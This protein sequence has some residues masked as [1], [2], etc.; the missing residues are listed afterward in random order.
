[1]IFIP[2]SPQKLNASDVQENSG[3]GVQRNGGTGTVV[4]FLQ[5]MT[6]AGYSLVIRCYDDDGNNVDFQLLAQTINGFTIL[7]TEDCICDFTAILK[8]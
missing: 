2:A 1:M 3:V 8:S 6:T 7:P 5:S 4:N